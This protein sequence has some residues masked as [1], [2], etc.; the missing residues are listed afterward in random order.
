MVAVY[1]VVGYHAKRA[2]ILSGVLSHEW[3]DE[4][5]EIVIALPKTYDWSGEFEL[6]LRE[7][8]NSEGGPDSLCIIL[9]TCF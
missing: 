8:V 2:L 5:P 3:Q 7:V 1:L 4:V 9:N 6:F